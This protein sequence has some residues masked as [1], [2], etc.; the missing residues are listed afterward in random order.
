MIERL[1]GGGS[2]R[3]ADDVVVEEPMEIRLDGHLVTTTMRTPGHDFE[4]AAGF[5][6]S[7]GLLHGAAITDIRYCATGTAI[8]TEFNVVTVGTRGH[9][10]EPTARLT[11]TSSSCGLCGSVAIDTVCERLEPLSAL[12]VS[13][14]VLSS[15]AA[16]LKDAQ[17]LFARTGSSHAAAAFEIGSGTVEI[18]REDIGRHNAADKVIG[19]LVLDHRLPAA[20]LGLFLSGRVS[21]EMVQKAWAAGFGVLAS[22]G[23]PSSLAV[24]LAR[25]ANIT[26][27]AFVRG[28]RLNVYSGSVT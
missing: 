13:S 14:R 19:R 28:D 7:E 17:P 25:R 9:A 12:S 6:L 26:L 24:D 18:L 3:T 27:A 23:G 22:V 16:G 15:V 20:G 8:D 1:D 5:C 4:L 11:P 21:L 2:R 10:P